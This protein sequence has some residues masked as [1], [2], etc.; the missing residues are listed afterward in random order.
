[1]RYYMMTAHMYFVACDEGG[2]LVQ[3]N[4]TEDIHHRLFEL[5][6]SYETV[7]AD[8]PLKGFC[9]LKSGEETV[10]FSKDGLFLCAEGPPSRLDLV[11]NRVKIGPWEKFTIVRE[12]RL[13]SLQDSFNVSPDHEI[14]RF[15]K[16]VSAHIVRQNSVKLYIG[17]GPL[18][19]PG[20]LNI[21][22]TVM[23][24]AFFINSP[25]EYFIFP[26][27]DR[28]WGLPD[29][30][31]DY[32]F[33]EDFIEHISQLQQIQFL[34][35]ALRVLKPGQFH[36][37]NTP[38]LLAAVKRHSDFSKGFEGVYTGE[39]KWGH[40]CLFSPTSLKEMAEM[41]GYREIVFTTRNHG[42]S[43]FAEHDFRPGPDRD[44]IFGNIYADL[45]K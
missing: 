16:T 10:S 39:L 37:I 40:V 34:A 30:S 26:Y 24:P 2:A 11:H 14:A 42:V 44:E 32:I 31:V 17:C 7:L 27:A 18:P 35:E 41:V 4:Y 3:L 29:N 33:H 15:A 19:R 21:D 6:E 45:L 8:G 28:P 12:D 43:A 20:F 25:T 9:M 22:I 38:N 36:R 5:P 13:S 1:M 23:A